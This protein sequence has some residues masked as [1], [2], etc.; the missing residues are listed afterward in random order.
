MHIDNANSSPSEVFHAHSAD[1]IGII[2]PVLINVTNALY[3]KRL[4]SFDNRN[5]ILKTKEESCL[6]KSSKLINLLKGKLQAHK[7]PHQYLVDICLVLR[8][9]HQRLKEITKFILQKLGESI[10]LF[11]LL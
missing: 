4:L 7:D 1:L 3:A 11:Y 8:N 5:D 9:Q 10:K 2:T 6:M